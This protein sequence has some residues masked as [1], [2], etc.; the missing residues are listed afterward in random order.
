[1][2][3]E[4][5][6]IVDGAH[7]TRTRQASHAA[8]YLTREEMLVFLDFLDAIDDE[9]EKGLPFKSPDPHQKIITY[10]MRRHLEARLTTVTTLAFAAGVPYATAMRRIGEMIDKG[11]IIQRP[12][13]KTG[14]SFSL[15]PSP[16][17]IEAWTDY[18]R[19]MKRL[20]GRTMGLGD[21]AS[22][23]YYFGG[24]YLAARI[25]PL[26]AVLSRPLGITP[27]LDILVHADPTF[28]AMDHLK[29]QFEQMLG[30]PIRFRALSIDR[31]R[32]GALENAARERSAYDIIA[33]D[34]PWIGEFAA[35]G[36][37]SPLDRLVEEGA[38]HAS[39]FHSA[40]WR[41]CFFGGR[42]W[43]IP[44][45]TTPELLF[46]RTDLFEE[47][48]IDPPE[49]A[50]AVL[51]AARALHK[52]QRGMRGIAWNAARGTALGHTVM[53]VM[54]AFG[55]P[56]LNLRPLS[57]G[58]DADELEG[59]H[60]RP[61]ILSDAGRESAEYLRALLDV[62]PLEILTMSWYERVVAYGSGKVAMAYGYTLL[63]PF[64]ELDPDRPAHGRT[65]YLPHPTG[66]SGSPIAPLGGY[67]LGV[68]A[69]LP[70]DRR[71]AVEQA[72]A[73]LTSAEACKLYMLNGSLVTPR[74]SVG[75]DPEVR[76]LSP[77]V[78]AVD[79]MARGGLLQHWPR[80]P[81]AEISEV[82]AICGEEF[83]DML[84]G[85]VS[86]EDALLR[87]QNR[88][89]ALMRANGHY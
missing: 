27:P 28:M 38:V 14:K 13:T 74:F 52:P 32:L 70:A 12:R 37:L 33:V 85:L 22:D 88:A 15:H 81:A 60:M 39:D 55:Q 66:P 20:V 75:A 53:M 4:V 6:G 18:A 76:A 35:K 16:Q 57:A 46:Y 56:V 29:R 5:A 30:L 71:P 63:A 73:L 21:A 34:M 36:V 24:S 23:D 78:G 86:I 59:E 47:A 65:G 1:M 80:P 54:A 40:S 8:S 72:L 10:L 42:Q 64:F 79:A 61:C 11:F 45:Q 87:A 62:S 43:S 7:A 50:E 41:S 89:D 69:N 77:L 84:R 58:F 31:L 26:P 83:H 68:P 82:I 51:A 17:L 25:I 19:R 48:G 2:G 3:T 67:V 49:T 9:A 44:I